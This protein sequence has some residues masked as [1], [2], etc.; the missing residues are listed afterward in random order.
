MLEAIYFD[1]NKKNKWI[2]VDRELL[3]IVLD[4]KKGTSY[5]LV[6]DAKTFAETGRANMDVPFPFGFHG[7][8]VPRR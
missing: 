7:N 5:P 4:G 2:V 3:S 1:S 6:L 8:H